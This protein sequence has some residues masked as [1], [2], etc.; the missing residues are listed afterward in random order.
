[1]Y[2]ARGS[3]LD[4]EKIDNFAKPAWT[5]YCFSE[6]RLARLTFSMADQGFGAGQENGSEM[7]PQLVEIA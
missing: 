4:Q 3:A 7:A 2:R 1:M 6:S 5:W